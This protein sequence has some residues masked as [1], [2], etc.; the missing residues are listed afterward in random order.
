M[1]IPPTQP[2][3]VV[4]ADVR[5]DAVG[6][7]E[8]IEQV[9]ALAVG[10][11]GS[12]QVCVG[13]NANVCNLAHDDAE[14]GQL[15]DRSA[16]NY[17]DGQSVVWAARLLGVTIPERVATTDLA[18]PLLRRA[19]ER[20]LPAF[21]LG[22]TPGTAERAAEKL[23]ATIPNLQLATHHGHFGETETDSVVAA[24]RAHGTR[25]LFVGMGDPHQARWAHA[26]GAT[27]GAGAVLTCGGLF[28]WLSG[29]NK[30]APKWMIR[31]GLE[32]LW[33]LMLEPRRLARRYLY[34]NPR[35]IG[36]VLAQRR[37]LR[38]ERR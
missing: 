13:V 2:T 33:R 27:T 31:G 23:R 4:V 7:D 8:V 21:F 12:S 15:L 35:F 25:I 26:H 17:A 3:E 29:S 19:A 16:L 20:G 30:R 36:L 18:E 28:D 1:S 24:I 37:R 11:A 38:S 10:A 9:L 6:M 5:V 14:F 32:W 22:A 34:G